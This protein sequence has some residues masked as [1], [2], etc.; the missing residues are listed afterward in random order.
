[1]SAAVVQGIYFFYNNIS[2]TYIYT[3]HVYSTKWQKNVEPS[4]IWQQN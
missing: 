4:N 3:W 1:M 2:I